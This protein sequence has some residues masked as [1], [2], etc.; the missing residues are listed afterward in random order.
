MDFVVGFRKTRRQHDSIW[1]IIDRMTKSSHFILVNS[2]YGAD[3]N[4][5]L[6]IYEI[7]RL[8]GIPL[9]IVYDRGDQ[10]TLH[11]WRSFQ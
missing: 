2:T 1:V 8:H 9:S 11:L 4:V 6:N 5:R 7:V 10:F 3:Y